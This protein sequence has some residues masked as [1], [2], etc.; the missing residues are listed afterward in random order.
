[1]HVYI[2]LCGMIAAEKN[3]IF[4]Q[5]ICKRDLHFHNRALYFRNGAIYFHIRT[6]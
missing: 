1:M 3:S 5:Y 4:P 6:L 2:T